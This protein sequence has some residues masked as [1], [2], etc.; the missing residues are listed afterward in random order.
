MTD[1]L[2]TDQDG[3]TLESQRK[4]VDAVRIKVH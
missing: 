4:D 1:F 3:N 2:A